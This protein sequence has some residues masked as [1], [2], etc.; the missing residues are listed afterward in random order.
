MSVHVPMPPEGL[1][2][3]PPP[4]RPH[5]GDG[6]ILFDEIKGNRSRVCDYR[7]HKVDMVRA[8]RIEDDGISVRVLHTVDGGSL[9]V[10]SRGAGDLPD[11][12][13]FEAYIVGG[14]VECLLD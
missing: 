9:A 13:E 7:G 1:R 3:P 11:V 5:P 4:R 14:W 12:V 8:W 6:W 2:P 10:L